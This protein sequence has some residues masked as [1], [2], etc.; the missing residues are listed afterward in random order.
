VEKQD[1][2]IYYPNMVF[3]GASVIITTATIRVLCGHGP[4]IC[5]FTRFY[6]KVLVFHGVCLP[7]ARAEAGMVLS[8]GI[9][10]SKSR[11]SALVNRFM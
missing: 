6:F 5:C 3:I 1:I 4:C 8:D 11:V 9:Q 7:A 10:T 2:M